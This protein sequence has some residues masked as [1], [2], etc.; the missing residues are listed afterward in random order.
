[1]NLMLSQTGLDV[2]PNGPGVVPGR[3]SDQ[4]PDSTTKPGLCRASCSARV[5]QGSGGIWCGRLVADPGVHDGCGDQVASH[6]DGGAA[7]V[8]D[9]VDPDDQGDALRRYPHADQ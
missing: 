5:S 9:A 7:H 3:A 6:V 1:M 2:Q 8:Q 4:A